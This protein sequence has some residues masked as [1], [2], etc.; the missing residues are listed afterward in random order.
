[1]RFAATCLA[2]GAA[3]LSLAAPLGA[4]E[5]VDASPPNDL[6]VTIYRNP[7][8]DPDEQ[9]NRNYPQGFAM[10]S[11]TRRV[12]LPKGES[13][14]RFEGV[15]EGMIG[16]SA[17]VTGLPG[18]TIEKNRNAQLLSPAALVDGT[19]GNRVTI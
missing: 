1:M 8:R 12:T 3:M 10:I 18:G 15:A 4:R 9:L 13:T 7:D 11:E 6:S 2:A 16:V 19:L 5:V 14:I 17:I